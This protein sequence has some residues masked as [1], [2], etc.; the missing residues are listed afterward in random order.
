MEAIITIIVIIGFLFSAFVNFG[1]S[2]N[3]KKQIASTIQPEIIQEQVIEEEQEP[4]VTI[5][6]PIEP[7]VA[8]RP[9]PI[10]S[11][12]ETYITVSPEQNQIISDTNK[13]VFEFKEKI[14]LEQIKERIYFETKILGFDNDWNKTYSN[15]R[16]VFLP[17]GQYIFLVRA[18]TKNIID[19]SP[20]QTSFKINISPYF[21]KVN[22]SSARVEYSSRPSLI[23]LNTNI[24]D[25][26]TINIT[27]WSIEGKQG[28]IAIPQGVEKYYHYYNSYINEDIFVKKG[29]RI[30]L[31][32]G[33]NPLGKDKNFRLNKCMGYLTSSFD[34]PVSVPKSCPKPTRQDVSYLEP[35]CQQFIL[36]LK[37]CEIPDYSENINVRSDKE[38]IG[39]INK[40]L[41]NQ[42]CFI[43][44]SQDKDFLNNIWYIYLD[45]KDI[46]ANDCYDTLY[47]K[48]QNGLVVDTYSYG[49]P[50]CR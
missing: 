37:T 17:A 19:Y 48:D 34:F 35:C 21:D 50:V 41:N 39:Y 49:Q 2:F 44:H 14:L 6:T 33:Y 25:N 13:V 12:I 30:Y 7:V 15:R 8:N 28:K 38:C 47:L 16:T 23:T 11:L 36:G 46:V 10:I 27:N 22:I 24:K 3:T 9:A 31:S 43:N 40:N 45:G 32:G 5:V 18:R 26:K 4:A 29:D 42:A 20:A 1:P